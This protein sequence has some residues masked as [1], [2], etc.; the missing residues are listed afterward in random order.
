MRAVRDVPGI[1]ELGVIES[2]QRYA[3]S[4]TAHICDQVRLLGAKHGP[5]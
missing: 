3:R 4:V 2:G 1:A 5:I